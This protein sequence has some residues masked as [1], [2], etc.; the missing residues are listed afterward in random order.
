M[1]KQ[2]VISSHLSPY[3]RNRFQTIANIFV[4]GIIMGLLMAFFA[5][6]FVTTVSI[7]SNYRDE[8][9]VFSIARY[10]HCKIRGTGWRLNK[11]GVNSWLERKYFRI[12]VS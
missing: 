9:K 7:I 2:N 5:N 4:F 3:A 12:Y 11:R 6:L 1:E 8:L 10:P